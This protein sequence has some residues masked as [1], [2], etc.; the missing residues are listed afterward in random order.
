[1]LQDEKRDLMMC[2]NCVLQLDKIAKIKQLTSKD[3]FILRHPRRSV[4]INYPVRMDNGIIKIISAFRIQYNDSLGP[5]KGGIR[6]HETVNQED[7][8][9]LAFLMTLKTS[10]VGIPYGGAK[11]GVKIN[12]KELSDGELERVSR[13]YVREMFAFIGPKNDIPAPDVNT[14]PKIM[15]WMMDEY[16]KIAGE[17]SPG[18][19]TGK[20]ILLGGSFGRDSSTAKGIFFIIEEK[21]KK[22]KKEKLKVSIQGFGNAGS[23][24]AKFLFDAGY[25]VVAVSDSSSGIYNEKGLNIDKLKEFKK[26]GGSFSDLEE[27]LISN[28]DVLKLDVDI[29]VPAALGGVISEENVKDIKAKTIL[30]LANAPIA[31]EVDTYLHEVGIEVVPD[32]LSNSGGVIVSYFE[33]VQ[34]SQNYYWEEDL[35]DE[36]LKKVILTTYKKVLEESKKC[37]LNL[38]TTSYFI[39]INRILKAEKLRGAL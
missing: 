31:P 30:E 25:K 19:F 14:S 28:E 1:M 4:N 33:W 32:I 38:R 20:P 18:A 29:L 26:S 34:N 7:V 37:N 39:A 3:L 15:G 11:G 9:E 23:T 36:K 5:T 21:Y 2:K 27:E 8:V 22:E 12:P 10:L 24:L 17:K 35:V 13:G 16:E 6:F